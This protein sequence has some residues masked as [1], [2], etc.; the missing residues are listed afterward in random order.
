MSADCPHRRLPSLP[1]LT[2][3]FHADPALKRWAT[4]F[5]L[6]ARDLVPGGSRAT[7]RSTS[8]CETRLLASR[9]QSEGRSRCVRLDLL[10]DEMIEAV[11]PVY[12]QHLTH[13]DIR[14]I[15]DFYNSEPGQK[16]LKEM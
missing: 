11:I 4:L 10:P 1:G 7:R 8:V 14:G 13:A 6:A 5:R 15:I 16:Y 12:Q 2:P 9:D 3:A